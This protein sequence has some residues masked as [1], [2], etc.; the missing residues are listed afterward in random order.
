[1]QN[2]DLL[3]INPQSKTFKRRVLKGEL[4][5]F[6]VQILVLQNKKIYDHK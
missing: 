2:C 3:T 5:K 6:K 1:M 4:K